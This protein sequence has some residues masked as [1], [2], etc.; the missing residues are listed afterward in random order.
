MD[1]LA[2]L[3]LYAAIMTRRNRRL[4][5]WGGVLVGLVAL[6]A[7]IGFLVVPAVA[8]P[9]LE[10]NASAA[11]QRR[12]TIAEMGF[13][14]FTFTTTLRGLQVADRPDETSGA[15]EPGTAAEPKAESAAETESTAE[16][17][18]AGNDT[19]A[20]AGTEL[21][22]WQ[23][24]RVNFDAFESLFRQRWSF[25]EV[26]L[27]APRIRLAIDEQGRLNIADLLERPASPQDDAEPVD[28]AIESVE[29]RQGAFEF[30]D[31]SRETEFTTSVAPMNLTL[32]EVATT[33]ETPGSYQFRASTGRNESIMWTGTVS[34]APVASE[35]RFEVTG[36]DLPAYMPYLADVLA[37]E[38]RSGRA[39]IAGEYAVA[40]GGQDRALLSG[41][42]L[43]LE[44]L[45]VALPEADAPAIEIPHVTL[46][47]PEADLLARTARIE[48]IEIQQP[49]LRAARGPDGTIDLMALLATP[50]GEE[51]APAPEAAAPPPPPEGPALP[52]VSVATIALTGGTLEFTDQTTPRPATSRVSNIDFTA[53]RVST[54]LDQP[55]QVMCDLQWQDGPGNVHVEGTVVPA[56]LAAQLAVRGTA[57][58]L[59]PLEPYAQTAANLAFT[60][61]SLQFDG[62]L[63][64]ELPDDAPMRIEWT[65]TFALDEL[66][67]RV[68]DAEE[69]L[70]RWATLKAGKAQV[71]LA[72]LRVALEQVEW[73]QPF[74]HVERDADGQLNFVAALS[75]PSSAAAPEGPPAA[76]KQALDL[77][78][79]GAPPPAA[80]A[81]R[82]EITVDQLVIDA[83]SMTFRDRSVD[84]EFTTAISNF[85][86]TISG[87]SSVPD[88]DPAKVELTATLADDTPVTIRGGIIHDAD[89]LLLPQDLTLQL[90]DLPLGM[91]QPYAT[92]YLGYGIQR[93]SAG[94][95]LAYQLDGD[96]LRGRNQIRLLDFF[97]GDQV[98]SP[99]ALDLPIKFALSILRNR[100][101]DIELN[102]PVSGSL[103]SPEFNFA[104]AAMSA[105]TGV[106]VRAAT[107]PFSVLGAIFGA[108][109]ETLRRIDFAPG[110]STLS[111]A[112]RESVQTLTTILQDR[113]GVQLA[114]HWA[115]NPA[116]DE[117]A[118]RARRL[119]ELI[120]Q[121]RQELAAADPAAAPTDEAALQALFVER[122]PEEA[123]A[124][125][126]PAV[127][128]GSEQTPDEPAGAP[129][130][131]NW[132]ERAWHWI[133]SGSDEPAETQPPAAAP[134]G[135]AAE[136]PALPDPAT[137]RQ[138]LLESVNLEPAALEGLAQARA[139]AVKQAL[140]GA[141]IEA[142]R[143]QIQDAS[144]LP[145]GVSLPDNAGRVAFTLQ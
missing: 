49:A 87:V 21:A 133:F 56:T 51:A 85:A 78:S 73:Q 120:A 99:D 68:P 94:F 91:F 92:R 122:F 55:V 47:M 48:R 145:Q 82:P 36:I 69:D 114:I 130:E 143:I 24:A 128:G 18:A 10:E 123:G 23:E 119:Q 1:F 2:G 129:R 110:E 112:G 104:S 90:Q 15:P 144:G 12:V 109:E 19:P 83:G 3:R 14:P 20:G 70:L 43:T 17:D 97:L 30:V 7:V 16:T 76:A 62:D 140:T 42:N 79:G 44:N 58:D 35:G 77:G 105:I 22:S 72:P 27:T 25:G 124:Q 121:R 138:R 116:A 118:L 39:S 117:P 101:G 6:Y 89:H 135:D 63:R 64:T 103:T 65:G 115:P 111:A 33:E 46:Q 26:V 31:R 60:G 125:A 5:V 84:P 98:E 134:E 136:A 71:S 11:L 45:A 137:M 66:A 13:N 57:L 53:N 96:N 34:A 54:A 74:V 141:G 126:P 88:S 52:E 37:G 4:L 127:A 131:R 95:D 113:P 108:D 93:G 32:T 38:L 139:E 29:I 9:R 81:A 28:F 67:V 50:P 75:P 102:V 59:S 86:G 106:F 8:R 142:S 107:Q 61:G 100:D 80:E 41:F 132:L 40:L